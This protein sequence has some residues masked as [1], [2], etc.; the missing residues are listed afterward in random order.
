MTPT[1]LDNFVSKL[2][3]RAKR[4]ETGILTYLEMNSFDVE[5]F[6][7]AELHR[8]EHFVFVPFKG[9]IKLLIELKECQT[10]K[11]MIVIIGKTTTSNEATLGCAS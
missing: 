1:R 3:S 2:C 5:V 11:L 6:M 4:W 9:L 8:L 7:G 10:L